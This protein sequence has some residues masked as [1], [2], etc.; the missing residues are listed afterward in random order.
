MRYVFLA[1]SLA[2]FSPSS[3]K[4]QQILKREPPMGALRGPSDVVF[5]DDGRC[6]RGQI[7]RVTGGTFGGTRGSRGSGGASTSR[8]RDVRA[9]LAL[10]RRP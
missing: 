1:L 2:F 8:G 4:A 10:N 3:A 6:P 5:V 9:A 7:K